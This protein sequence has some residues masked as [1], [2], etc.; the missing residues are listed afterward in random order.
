MYKVQYKPTK[1]FSQTIDS[2]GIWKKEKIYSGK[3]TQLKKIKIVFTDTKQEFAVAK[4]LTGE[5]G[6]T[7][8]SKM[9]ENHTLIITIQIPSVLLEKAG[10]RNPENH[11]INKTINSIVLSNLFSLTHPQLLVSDR[12]TFMLQ[13]Y[14][15]LKKFTDKP[16]NNPFHL[17]MRE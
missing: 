4:S 11:E 15:E 10:K 13:L 6:W 1:L 12:N 3:G 2:W 8:G 14:S 16:D 9:E 17:K 7:A 5:E